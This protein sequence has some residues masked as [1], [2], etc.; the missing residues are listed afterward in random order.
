MLGVDNA[1]ESA[2][3]LH[4]VLVDVDILDALQESRSDLT[5][6]MTVMFDPRTHL[7]AMRSDASESI[8]IVDIYASRAADVT[9][10]GEM[11]FTCTH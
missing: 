2:V 1:M 4:I 7:N 10:N 8:S 6:V 11:P 3:P 5:T 9:N